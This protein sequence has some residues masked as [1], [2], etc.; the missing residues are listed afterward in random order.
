MRIHDH[1]FIYMGSEMSKSCKKQL[2]GS[3]AFV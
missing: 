3:E 2:N 1:R